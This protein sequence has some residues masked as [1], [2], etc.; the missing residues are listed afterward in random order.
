MGQ[1][2]FTPALFKFLREL[3][4]NNTSEWFKANQERYEHDVRQPMLGFILAF[5]E[6]LHGISAQFLADP[7][8]AGGSMFRINRDIRFSADKSPYKTHLGAQFRHRAGSRDVHSPGFYLHLE[9]RG[10][11]GGGGLWHPDPASLR[12]VRERMVA[13]PREWTGLRGKGLEVEGERLARV[14]Q[15]FDPASPLAE[16]LKLKDFFTSTGFTEGQVCSG[17]FLELFVEH[18]R[19]QVPLMKFLVKAL[20]L[21]W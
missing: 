13:H 7:S 14:P 19:A 12:K 3:K 21:P 17:E 2:Y 9:P 1:A 15:G 10:C 20:D 18:C 11:F 4:E 5:G 16:D 6:P 8:R